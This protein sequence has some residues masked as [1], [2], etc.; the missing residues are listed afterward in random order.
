MK[1]KVWM[2]SLA[3][4]VGAGSGFAQSSKATEFSLGTKAIAYPRLNLL[5]AERTAEGY[6]IALEK[7]ELL[8][9]LNASIGKELSSHWAVQLG[10]SLFKAKGIIALSEL[11]IEHRLGAYFSRTAYIDP[12][13]SLG[14]G[15][16]YNEAIGKDSGQSSV[17][18][19]PIAWQA[20]GQSLWQ[21]KHSLPL[22]LRAGV[23]LWLNDHWGIDLNAGYMALASAPRSGAWTA[24]F[25]LRY[26]L[27]GRR[28]MPQA[29]LQYIDR[30]IEQVVEKP[31]VI[32]KQVPI[33]IN[34]VLEGI[35]FDFGSSELSEASMPLVGQ[36]AEWMR[37]DT[38]K[39]FLITGFTDAV[40]TEDYNERLSLARAKT[41][42]SALVSR[43]ISKEQ[44]KCRGV[45][46]RIALAPRSSG[47]E[48]RRQDRKILLEV[49]TNE[50]YW[51]RID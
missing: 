20:Q 35:Y 30:W 44:I 25:G 34:E 11:Q 42:A 18:G 12:Y 10:Q 23:K 27:G 9:G 43:G 17:V 14:I 51:Q 33:Y 2:M 46:K 6:H 21:H 28:K 29:E 31:I 50:D 24:G 47:S 36:L 32:E 48:T 45:G 19:R 4:L 26:R 13:L 41:L 22:S 7:Q 16:L 8:F 5:S 40:G 39:R 38:N 49:I 15:Y 1:N 37:Q 3:L